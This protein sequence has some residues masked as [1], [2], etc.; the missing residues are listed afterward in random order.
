MEVLIMKVFE[1]KGNTTTMNQTERLSSEFDKKYDGAESVSIK[2]VERIAGMKEKS[3]KQMVSAALNKVGSNN[4]ASVSIRFTYQFAQEHEAEL[5]T[6]VSSIHRY[7]DKV[8]N[9]IVESVPELKSQGRQIAI[10]NHA[11]SLLR[12]WA[13]RGSSYTDDQIDLAMDVSGVLT[14]PEG[15][16][17]EASLTMGTLM[18]NLPDYRGAEKHYKAKTVTLSDGRSMDVFVKT[19]E[20]YGRKKIPFRI[21]YVDTFAEKIVDFA[22]LFENTMK[23][24]DGSNESNL[25]SIL[26]FAAELDKVSGKYTIADLGM[27][28]DAVK[29]AKE[30]RDAVIKYLE[31]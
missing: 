26:A 6:I 16:Y 25:Q 27:D 23:D 24:S 7:N 17:L 22:T 21:S 20:S 1:F 30:M 28:E 29:K 2:S 10:Q 15:G 12:D 8:L 13:D 9:D 14:I 11:R 18:H 4:S 3:D 5:L 19:S 31:G